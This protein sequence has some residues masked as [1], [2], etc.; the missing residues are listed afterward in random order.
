MLLQFRRLDV[1]NQGVY[2]AMLSLKSPGEN[3]LHAFLLASD[4]VDIL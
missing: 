2:S 4:V 1:Q 3:I